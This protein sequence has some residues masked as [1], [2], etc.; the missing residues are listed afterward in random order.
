MSSKINFVAD[1]APEIG[2][3]LRDLAR[4][5]TGRTHRAAL[6]AG[7]GLENA[8]PEVHAAFT[9]APYAFLLRH[10][11]AAPPAPPRR[12]LD[13]SC[14][15]GWG[16]AC[17]QRALGKGGSVI[18]TD[19]AVPVVGLAARS[20]DPSDAAFLAADSRALPFA[21]GSFDLVSSVLGIVHNMIPADARLCLR[22]ISRVLR[23]G[24]TLVF[25]TPHRAFSQD[26]YHPNPGDDPSLRFSAL[27]IHEY[28]LAELQ[29]LG[30]E[31][32]AE[33]VFSGFSVGGLANPV[34]REVWAELVSALG[35][36]RFS[37]GKMGGAASALARRLLPPAARTRLFLRSVS[38]ACSRR[39]ISASDIARAARYHPE[40]AGAAADHFVVI[41]RKA[42]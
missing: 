12:V 37:G 23:K 2:E 33:G 9:V 40:A 38:A 19:I 39:G 4:R 24:G 28:S 11:R 8:S 26:L 29:E 13:L 6:S 27:N 21:P 17:L 25:T 16:A 15:N 1:L 22:E 42:D 7:A 3:C 20:R 31:L 14:G 5:P 35:R 18:G 34:F 10:I 41:A 32:A 30:R 36:K